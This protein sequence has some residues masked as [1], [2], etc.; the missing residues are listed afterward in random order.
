MLHGLK[1]IEQTVEAA[2]KQTA[3]AAVEHVRQAASAAARWDVSADA[4]QAVCAHGE[5]IA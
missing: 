4:M 2:G 5:R 1:S 3:G